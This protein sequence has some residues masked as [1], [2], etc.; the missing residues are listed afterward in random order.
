[1]KRI[2]A[3]LAAVFGLLL[4]SPATGHAD[5]VKTVSNG[6]KIVFVNPNPSGPY[7]TLGVVGTDTYGNHVALTAAHCVGSAAS[8]KDR[9]WTDAES[10]QGPVYDANDVGFGPIGY[11]R[12]QSGEQAYHDVMVI[13]LVDGVTMSSQ[14]PV[15]R[16]DSTYPG[17]PPAGM[18]SLVAKYG[19]RTGY[20][21]G[22]IG[23]VDN[24]LIASFAAQSGGDSGGPVVVKDTTQWVGLTERVSFT[25]PPYISTS[26]T[27]ILNWLDGHAV[28][29]KGF[30]PV[31]N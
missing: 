24:G 19:A 17:I 10:A 23:F 27:N 30:V 21:W 8:W 29:G 14:G 7:C 26:A 15:L 28:T 12:F 22:N 1:M 31:N 13:K 20:T 9:E 6:T 16:I 4:L 3:T 2:T 18:N 5:V 11:I 25:W